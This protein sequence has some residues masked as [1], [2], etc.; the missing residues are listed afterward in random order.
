MGDT[1]FTIGHSTDPQERFIALLRQH[2]I[3]A[4]CDVRS[5]PYSQM[6]PQFNREELEEALLAHG[7][8]YRF[9]GEELG[10]RSDDPHC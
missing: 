2:G 8:A 7:I 1:V 6:N 9:L 5:K 10:A 4:L 3:I